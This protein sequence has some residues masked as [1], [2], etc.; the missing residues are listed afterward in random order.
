MGGS[1]APMPYQPAHSGAVDAGL[2]QNIAMNNQH[3][4]MLYDYAKPQYEG[5]YDQVKNNPGNAAATATGQDIYQRGTQAGNDQLARGYRMAGLA[6][7][8]I[9]SGWDPQS[10]NM[11]WGLGQV[12]GAAG[13]NASQNGLAGSPFG[14]GMA[15]DAVGNFMRQW[16]AGAQERQGQGIDQLAKINTS[17]NDSQGRGLATITDSGLLPQAVAND[18]ANTQTNALNQLVQGLSAITSSSNQTAASADNYLNTGV[19]AAN[20]GANVTK[21]NNATT[22]A[23]WGAIGQ[24]AGLAAS[25]IPK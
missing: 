4:G 10:A 16:M 7:G 22:E 3:T 18:Q 14:A 5:L 23:M 12:E 17:A 20:A 11:N 8:A 9:Q 19:N 13:V 1:K 24:A 15:N 6:P 21:A 2:A 25:F